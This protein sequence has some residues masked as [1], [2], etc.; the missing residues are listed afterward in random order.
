MV[1]ML[2]DSVITCN[3]IIDTTG[4]ISIKN[5]PK[6]NCSKKIQFKKILYF[7]IPFINYD[8]NYDRTVSNYVIN[9]Q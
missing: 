9:Y 4:C 5:Y 3:E 8:S 7:T 2:V 6:K 1:N